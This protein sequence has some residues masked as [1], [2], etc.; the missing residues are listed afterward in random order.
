MAENWQSGIM[1]LFPCHLSSGCR[2]ASY[3]RTRS[4]CSSAQAPERPMCL[5]AIAAITY[6]WYGGAYRGSNSSMK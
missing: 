6:Q 5:L 3:C 2:A 4:I 1:Y